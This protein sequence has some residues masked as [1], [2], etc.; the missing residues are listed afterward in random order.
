[1]KELCVLCDSLTYDSKIKFGSLSGLK[2]TKP[3][4]EGER[5]QSRPTGQVSL[6][7]THTDKHRLVIAV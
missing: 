2:K 3:K 7:Q 4:Q 1:M 5:F 6:P